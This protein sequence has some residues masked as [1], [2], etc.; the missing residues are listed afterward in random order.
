MSLINISNLTFS[1]QGTFDNVFE[2][3]SFQVDTNWKLG[4]IGRN[5]RGKTTFLNLLM[6][7]YEYTGT[8]SSS[9]QFEYFP[10]EVPDGGQNVL[11]VIEKIVGQFQLWQLRRELSILEVSEEILCRPFA[12]LSSGEQTKVLLA[13]LFLKEN[14]FLLI[15]EPT[16]HLDMRARKQVSDYLQGK[17]G[18]ILV[19]H[20][21]TFLDCC[22]DHVLSINKV[23]IEIQK[24][25]FSSWYRNKERQDHDEQ[26]ENETLKKEINHL[27]AAARRA[28]NWSDQAEKT[29]YNTL[30]SGLKPDK[31]Y[32][33]HKAAKMMKRSKAIEGRRGAAAQDKSKLLKNIERVEQLHLNPM[34]YF[35]NRLVSLRDVSILYNENT[36]RMKVGFSIDQYDRIA[37]CGKNGSGKSS[38]L[39]L[40][41]GE[42]IAFRGDL[43]KGSNLII[44]YVPQDA[45]FLTGNLSNFAVEHKLDES[46]FKSILRK[47]DFSREQFERNMCEFSGGQKKKVLI[48]KSLSEKAHLYIWDEPLNFI[49]VF[50]RMQIEELLRACRSTVL[51]VEHDSAFVDAVATKQITL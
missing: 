35:A 40:I 18:F 26:A 21:R 38:I 37:L 15:D 45:S 48:A 31:G 7:R 50:S 49:D 8:I 10:Y 51:F 11:R 34:Q 47:L 14:S 4:F 28:S 30:N 46:L 3:V 25:N 27:Q 42:P 41:L 17:K 29:K 36:A 19:S 2:N 23:N 39:K 32:I 6:G 12:S 5:G 9:V 24:G 43:Q 33:G 20:D 13:S 44:S 1:Y 22:I 16:N